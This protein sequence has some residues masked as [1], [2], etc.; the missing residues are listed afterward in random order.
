[1]VTIVPKMDLANN[2]LSIEIPLH[3]RGKGTLLVKTPLNPSK[4]ELEKMELVK[5]IT[6]WWVLEEQRQ[7]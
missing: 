4:E 2:Q 1:M 3:E 5:D 6:I 7:A